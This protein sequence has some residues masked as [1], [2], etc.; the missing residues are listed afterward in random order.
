[1]MKVQGLRYTGCRNGSSKH[2][3]G[4][5]AGMFDERAHS[6]KHTKPRVSISDIDFMEK[7]SPL[8]RVST[9]NSQNACTNAGTDCRNTYLAAS[10]VENRQNATLNSQVAPARRARFASTLSRYESAPLHLCPHHFLLVPRLETAWC[11]STARCGG[12]GGSLCAC[13][14]PTLSTTVWGLGLPPSPP[15]PPRTLTPPP[16]ESTACWRCSSPPRWCSTSQRRRAPAPSLS[17]SS[18]RKCPRVADLFHLCRC[19]AF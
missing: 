1:M 7:G 17:E 4:L 9:P 14:W 3:V 18:L 15:P 6:A 2:V 16:T 19:P 11:P 13:A 10:K 8:V 5:D 12:A